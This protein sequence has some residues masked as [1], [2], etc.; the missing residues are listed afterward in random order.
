MKILCRGLGWQVS[1]LEQVCTS[2]LPPLSMPE[3]L[4][5]YKCIYWQLD[6]KDNVE[7]RL[8]LELLHPFAA[9]KNLYLSEESALRIAPALQEL[10]EGTRTMEVLF[11]LQNIF[12]EGLESSGSVNEGI[13]QFVAARQVVSH[14]IAVSRWANSRQD[15]LY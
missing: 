13:G 7:N 14:P 3:D 6:P 4:Y 11:C 5:I 10:S 8:W 1:S 15:K 9:L 2:A 12:S